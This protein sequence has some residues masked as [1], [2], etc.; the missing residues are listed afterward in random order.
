MT[1]AHQNLELR[2]TPHLVELC[3]Q[4][5][6]LTILIVCFLL[7]VF[8][9]PIRWLSEGGSECGTKTPTVQVSASCDYERGSHN[10]PL[11]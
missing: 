2:F 10:C 6:Y 7:K 1:F 8:V 4:D 5:L 11:G 9:G 3:K